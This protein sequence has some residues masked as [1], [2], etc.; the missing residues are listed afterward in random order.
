MTP[1]DRRL[2]FVIL[3]LTVKFK[4]SRNNVKPECLCNVQIRKFLQFDEK[5]EKIQ[6]GV[7]KVD[8][9]PN[10][11]GICGCHCDV[12]NDRHTLTYYNFYVR[13]IS[14]CGSQWAIHLI[15]TTLA[16]VDTIILSLKFSSGL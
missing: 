10:L 11:P 1:C 7:K 13:G 3:D 2:R 12:E 15:Y 8:F 16:V 6:K 4:R 9:W 5:L 14:L